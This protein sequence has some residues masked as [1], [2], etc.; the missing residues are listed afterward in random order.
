MKSELG[1]AGATVGALALA[2]LFGGL[3]LAI[4]PGWAAVG[5]WMEQAAAP[6]WVQAVGSVGAI[7]GTYWVAERQ[8]SRSVVDRNIQ[9][10]TDRLELTEACIV[11]AEDVLAVLGEIAA[12]YEA[13]TGR[14]IHIPVERVEELQH[15]VRILIG[16]NVTPVVLKG[17]A[18]LQRALAHTARTE[19]ERGSKPVTQTRITLSAARRDLASSALAAIRNVQMAQAKDASLVHD[20]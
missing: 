12:R 9:R 8:W 15:T 17:L 7:V 13:R 3:V 16:K 6:A 20:A 4:Y 1:T 19:R 18:E 14:V 5:L 2:C 10:A 11:V